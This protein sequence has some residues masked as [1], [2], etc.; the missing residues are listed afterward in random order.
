M[1]CRRFRSTVNLLAATTLW[2]SW[3]AG[4]QPQ[5][6]AAA[7]DADQTDAPIEQIVVTARKR[8]EGLQDT[9]VAVTALTADQIADF[10]V[11]S[12]ADISKMTAGM[13]FDSEFGRG[14]NRPVIRGQANILGASGV[15]YFIDGVYVSGSIDDYDTDDIERIEIVKGPQSA[16]YGRNTYSGAINIV[17]RSPGEALRASVKGEA[18]GDEQFLLRASVSGPIA[19]DL[20]G[21]LTL[22]R[23][24]M[25]GH[26]TN[27][28][29]GQSIGEQESASASGVLEFT[30]GERLSVRVRGYWSAR[31]DGQPAIFAS[32][33]FDNDCYPDDGA[34]YA[35]AGR[36]FCGV[37]V[38]G[39]VNTDWT[40][41]APDARITDDILQMGARI[42]YLL[43]DSWKLSYI[44]GYGQRDATEIFDGDYL[45]TSFAGKQLHPE[46]FPLR[47]LRRRPTIPV[48]LCRQHDGLHLRQLGGDRRLL[49]R[50]AAFL[51]CRAAERSAGRV[52]L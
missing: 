47:R 12:L 42:D 15:S 26:V 16:L 11:Q 39:E 44:G 45:P 41:Q 31:D 40:V 2:L 7:P 23:Y 30:P 48:R 5:S 9:P 21:S 4:A 22:R 1:P 8:A 46:R 38:P 20:A 35:G 18:A 50:T 24:A 19:Q 17:T 28:H 13:L 14:S 36:Y 27:R 37:V 51:R 6:D 52:L 33:Y 10:G 34:L 49:A 32:R 3:S 29:D 25:G 43:N